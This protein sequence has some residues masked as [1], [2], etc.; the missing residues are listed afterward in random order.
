MQCAF[1]QTITSSSSQNT[2]YNSTGLPFF[3]D[4]QGQPSNARLYYAVA[5]AN[6]TTGTLVNYSANPVQSTQNPTSAL[7]FTLSGLTQTTTY[8]YAI[9]LTNPTSGAVLSTSTGSFTTL[10]LPVLSG[11]TSSNIT[12]NSATINYTIDPNGSSTTAILNYGLTTNLGQTVNNA[13]VS[14]TNPIAG[15]FSLTGLVPGATYFYTVTGSSQAGTTSASAVQSFVA[16]PPTPA[17]IYHWEFNNNLAATVGSV[18]FTTTSPSVNF[19]SNGTSVNSAYAVEVTAPNYG[20]AAN[21]NLPLL[22]Q[23]NAPRTIILR[24]NQL[25]NSSS[26]KYLYAYGTGSNTQI[27]GQSFALESTDTSMTVSGWGSQAAGYSRT[28]NYSNPSNTWNTYAIV[29]DGLNALIY[30]NGT[31]LSSASSIQNLNTTGTLFRLGTTMN[32][33]FGT[34]IFN[35]D[36]LKIYNYALTASQISALGTP[37]PL[38]SAVSSSNINSNAATINYSI[39]SN[40]IVATPVIKYGLSASNLNLTQNCPTVTSSTAT[41]QSQVLSGLTSNTNYFYR[42]EAS[43]ASGNATPSTTLSFTTPGTATVPAI[44]G[45]G[46][47]SGTITNTGVT[48]SYTLNPGGAT[49]TPIIEYGTSASNLNLSQTGNTYSGTLNYAPL[50]TLSGLTPGTQYFYRVTASNSVGN[51]IPSS[52]LNFTTTGTAPLTSQLLYHFPFNGNT[53]S[54]TVNPGTFINGSGTITYANDDLGNTSGALQVAVSNDDTSRNLNSL[55]ANLPLL[56]QGNSS[57][58]VAFRI[59]YLNTSITNFVVSWGAG[60]T[61]Q[62]YGFE[63]APTTASSAIWGNNIN[64][65]NTIAANVWRNIV[66]TYNANTGLAE[67]YDGGSLTGSNTHA[68]FLNNNTNGTNIV[69]GR[70]MLPTFGQGNFIIDD[71]KIYNYVLTPSEVS[72]LSTQDFQENKLLFTM[73]PNPA[74]DVVLVSMENELKSVEVYSLQGQKVL[75]S[76]QKEFNISQLNTGIYLVKIEDINGNV[77]SQKL[78]KK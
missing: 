18:P 43:S 28:F 30:V 46:V 17:L 78:I 41:V 33:V 50:Q 55:V 27:N 22:P 61:Y 65:A 1:G 60:T 15:T 3:V 56:P 39:N 68:S 34:G 71:L 29:Y 2:T 47:S 62:S 19:A 20:F 64:F 53:S 70:S 45:V 31:L 59:K 24:I 37:V 57:R 73:F 32:N 12:S 54:V 21:A 14:G 42:V 69:M 35:I 44:S 40:G 11:V 75:N 58:S 9:Q 63:K 26:I 49:T 74:N 52:I 23:A 8:N 6:A 48:I 36:D 4:P 76:S 77:A 51:A 13:A 72:A 7:S 66:I 16:T 38:I 25:T 10:T 67:F 5:P